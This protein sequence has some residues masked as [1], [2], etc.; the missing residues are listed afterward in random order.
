MSKQEIKDIIDEV[1]MP[2][3]IMQRATMDGF[4]RSP[5]KLLEI[6]RDELKERVSDE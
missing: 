3:I 2:H 6:V 5:S 1:F 4:G